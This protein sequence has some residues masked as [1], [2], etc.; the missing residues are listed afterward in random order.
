MTNQHDLMIPFYL[1]GRAIKSLGRIRKYVDDPDEIADKITEG[2]PVR[3][4]IGAACD[5]A[6][7]QYGADKKRKAAWLEEHKEELEDVATLIGGKDDAYKAYLQGCADELAYS[8]EPDVLD[9]LEGDYDEEG[10]DDDEAD[11]DS[12]EGDQEGDEA[13]TEDEAGGGEKRSR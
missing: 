2:T 13:D 12:A 9:S 5:E 6:A 10:D 3:I 7:K 1:A 4:A 11:D 8:L